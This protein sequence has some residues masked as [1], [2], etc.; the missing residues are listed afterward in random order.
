MP[1]VVTPPTGP[2]RMIATPGVCARASLR[3]TVCCRSSCSEVTTL[4]D[5]PVFE[6]GCGVRVAVTTTVSRL[7]VSAAEAG[8][9][10]SASAKT[11]VEETRME[12]MTTISW[13]EDQEPARNFLEQRLKWL[14]QRFPARD[15]SSLSS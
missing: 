6:A 2:L 12:R 11:E 3:T 8:N 4:T 15:D 10:E 9:A 1:M 13:F 7:R 5:N 14:Y